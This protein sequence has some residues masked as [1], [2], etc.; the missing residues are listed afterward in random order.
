MTWGRFF[1]TTLSRF[2]PPT[3]KCN[4]SSKILFIP[5]RTN[6]WDENKKNPVHQNDDNE[7]PIL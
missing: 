1:F 6:E 3:Q 4:K 2:I 7:N 5:E